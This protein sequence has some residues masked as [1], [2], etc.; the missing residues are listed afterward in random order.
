MPLQ[1]VLEKG[2]HSVTWDG[3]SAAGPT[4]ESVA[5]DLVMIDGESEACVGAVEAWRDHDPPPG[6]LVVGRSDEARQRS[7]QA[8]CCFVASNASMGELEGELLD[9]MRMR[10]AGRMSG[11]YARAVLG[12]GKALSPQSDAIRIISGSRQV[13]LALVRECLRWHACEYVSVNEIVESLRQNR[14]FQ[15]PELDVIRH[16][17]GT[18]T[19]QK[20]VSARSGS[21]VMVGRLLW[22]LISA[23][24]AS[25][26]VGP[27]N[28][29]TKARKTIAATRR[30][31]SARRERLQHATHYDVLEVTRDA[32]A[33]RVDYAARTLAIRY[34]PDRLKRLDLGELAGHVDPNWQQILVARQ[35]LMDG[36]DR[37]SYD[38][39]IESRRNQLKSPWAFEVADP[40]VAQD[41][42]RQGQAALVAGEAF[43]AV[44]S[45]AG[46][47]RNHPGH[48]NYEAYLCWARFRAEVERGGE[49]SEL[50]AKERAIAEESLVG[51]GPWPRA[52]VALALLCAA[53]ADP[54]SARYH[55]DEALSV[56]PN[57]PAA[58]QLLARL[59]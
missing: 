7:V 22:G 46:A 14:A 19:V 17:D 35:V 53:D 13:D 44:S 47:C 57:L 28:E 58:K 10:F 48:P 37:A 52:L 9:V 54:H 51:R 49:R 31:L 41:F 20:L 2:G 55:L 40:S 29:Q 11:P 38:E 24:A 30:H 3:A 50:S 12:L 4:S 33:Q 27:P 16:L 25:C 36:V 6:I 34:A 45:I 43:K 39:S 21:G 56:D 32:N 1:E 26:T 8:R 18:H 42:F 23:G 59:G 15:I 5:V